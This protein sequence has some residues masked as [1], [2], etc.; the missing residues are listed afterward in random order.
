GRGAVT[1]GVPGGGLVVA[2]LPVQQE[3]ADGD[4]GT[5]LRRAGRGGRDHEDARGRGEESTEAVS[6]GQPVCPFNAADAALSRCRAWP[7]VRRCRGVCRTRACLGPGRS[8]P[9]P[10]RPGSR[11]TTGPGC[12]PPR[13]SW[14]PAS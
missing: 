9:W 14:R 3:V 11:A 10:V 13:G 6:G 8:R 7:R 12:D 4:L 5:R 2:L 1:V